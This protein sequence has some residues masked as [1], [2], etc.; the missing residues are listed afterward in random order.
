MITLNA[1]KTNTSPA[2]PKIIS[3]SKTIELAP[4]T[5]PNAKEPQSH[6][7]IFAGWKLKKRKPIKAP[8]IET[9]NKVN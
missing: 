3:L 7:K 8:T 4:K 1:S 2:T 5:P 9:N 6:I